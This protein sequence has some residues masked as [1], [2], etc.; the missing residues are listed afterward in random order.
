MTVVTH[1]L[2]AHWIELAGWI[3]TGLGIWLTTRRTLWCWPV[4]LAADVL[5][6]VVFY[7][8]KLLSDALLQVFFV[9]FTVYGWWNWWRGVRQEGTVRVAPLPWLNSAIAIAA[10]IAGTF[11]L[12]AIAKRFNA[13]LPY[14]DASLASFSLVASWWQARKHIANWWLWI[15]VDVLYIGEYIYKDL[16]PTAVLYA[17]LVGLAILGL[18]EWR[19]APQE[20]TT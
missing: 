6:L 4:I 11:V 7:Q 1:Y 17:G 20:E 18:I 2:V 12:A 8:A 9:V 10:G 15:V 3:T 14:L 19:R 16:W 13:A 5:Y